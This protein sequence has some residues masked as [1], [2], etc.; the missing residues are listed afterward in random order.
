M[1]KKVRIKAIPNDKPN[2]R[3]YVRALIRLARELEEQ[4]RGASTP[5]SA[6]A[7]EGKDA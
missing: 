6:G 5:N 2:V 1:S 4:Q 7:S 3:L